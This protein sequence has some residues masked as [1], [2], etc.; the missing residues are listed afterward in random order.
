LSRVKF[1]LESPKHSEDG[2]HERD[3]QLETPHLQGDRELEE[4]PS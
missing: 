2:T 4:I 1:R 3:R